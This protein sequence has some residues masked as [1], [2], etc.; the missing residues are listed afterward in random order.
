LNAKWFVN[1]V[2]LESKAKQRGAKVAVHYSSDRK[3]PFRITVTKGGLMIS[4]HRRF[5]ENE[6]QSV[7]KGYGEFGDAIDV[8]S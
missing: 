4:F 5:F 6:L 2:F 1:H 3:G 7:M 8:Q